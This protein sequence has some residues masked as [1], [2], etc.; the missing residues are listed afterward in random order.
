V[1]LADGNRKHLAWDLYPYTCIAERCPTPTALFLTRQDLQ[2]HIETDHP[3]SRWTC[4]ICDDPDM[5]FVELQVLVGHLQV[6]HAEDIMP[7]SIEAAISWGAVKSY[8]LTSCPLCNFRGNLTLDNPDLIRHVLECTH[9]F[10]LRAL[11]W[12]KVD[13]PASS[14]AGTY[15]LTHPVADPVGTWL[16]G[17]VDE[18]I[19]QDMEGQPPPGLETRPCDFM[20][21]G[22]G[23]APGHGALNYFA[24]N[25]YFP[26]QSESVS[27]GR[28]R[29]KLSEGMVSLLASSLVSHVL[30]LSPEAQGEKSDLT[31][32][33]WKLSEG[34]TS[35]TASQPEAEGEE[36]NLTGRHAYNSL[37]SDLQGVASWQSE[38]RLPVGGRHHS[39][40]DLDMS[41]PESPEVLS[42][43]FPMIHLDSTL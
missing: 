11:P 28:K 5:T 42:I 29:T 30:A 12:P 7:N 8:G 35:Q 32:E 41:D 21:F 43:P 4:S 34:A 15:N 38:A 26:E 9:D 36:I 40:L 2:E 10:A 23:L 1:G 31:R 14:V 25:A 22:S 13:A 6:E 39:F 33:K 27:G 24:A 37:F 19:A 16:R 3:P 18:C 20:I 17:V